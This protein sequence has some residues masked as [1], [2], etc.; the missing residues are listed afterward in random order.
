VSAAPTVLVWDPIRSLDWSYDREREV[1]AAAGV[2]LV[3]PDGERATPEQV[4]S[5]TVVIVSGPFPR[6]LLSAMPGCAGIICYSVGMDSVDV[7][8]ATR[9]GIPVTNVAGYCTD[10]VADHAMT[11]LLALQRHLLPFAL[12]A[13]RGAW[14]VYHGTD[15]T[16][17]RRLRGQ[18]VGIIGLGRIGSQVAVRCGAFGMRVIAHDPFLDRPSV[19]GVDLVR[20]DELLEVSDTVVLCGALTDSSRGILDADR[21]GRMRPGAHL[22]N[23]SR[24]ALVEETALASALRSGR[25]GGAALDVRAQEPPPTPDPLAGLPNVLLTQHLAATSVE[26][27]D[28]LHVL[29]A[30]RALDLIAGRSPTAVPD[31]TPVAPGAKAEG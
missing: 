11:L 17:I 4:A 18:T 10:E 5:A 30:R 15:F 19:P 28:D 16:G 31:V 20:L 22:V 25:L 23:V 27:R 26:A 29:A 14:D 1:L 12:S 6:E 21:I 7:A 13:R 24:G 2:E 9:A 8:A 3:V